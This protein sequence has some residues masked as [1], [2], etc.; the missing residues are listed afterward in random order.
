MTRQ[1]GLSTNRA[2]LFDR[3]NYA[4]WS[5]RMQ[6]FLMALSF[7]IWKSDVIGY[8]TPTTPPIDVFGKMPSENN[9]KSMNVILCGLSKSEFVKAMHCES[10]KEI[11]DK[12]Q[13]IYEGDD[14]VKKEKLQIHRRQFESLKR[15]YEDNC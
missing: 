2:S 7:D 15:K 4:F 10:T 9:V 12:L 13:N 11:L 1:E 6:T 5:I 8:T 14:K 3:T